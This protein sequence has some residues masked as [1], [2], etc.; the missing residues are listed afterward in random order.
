MMFRAVNAGLVRLSAFES[1]TAP[2]APTALASDDT[3]LD[4]VRDWIRE[5]WADDAF[6]AAVALA[7]PALA[8]RIEAIDEGCAIDSRRLRRAA[9]ALLR[10]RLRVDN[11]A[12]PFGLFAGITP[13]ETMPEAAVEHGTAH[14]AAA[15]PDAIF[16]H[17]AIIALEPEL[18]HQLTVVANNLAAVHGGRL[19]LVSPA[20]DGPSPVEASIA[21]TPA[22]M[23]ALR[24][25]ADP[26]RFD[27]L[28]EKLASEFPHAP[29]SK[30]EPML[31]ALVTEDI[32]LTALRPPMTE[33]DPLAYLVLEARVALGTTTA[34]TA[35]Q[36]RTLLQTRRR[37]RDFERTVGKPH[38]LRAACRR[39]VDDTGSA[40]DRPELAVDLRIDS[41][42][43]LPSTVIDEAEVAAASLLR[44]TR[45]PDGSPSW[46]DFHHRFLERYG[47]GAL[48]P[49]RDLV[50][51]VSGIGYPATFRD[52]QLPRPPHALTDRDRLLIASAHQAVADRRME[53]DLDDPSLTGFFVP[54]PTPPPHVGITFHLRAKSLRDIDAGQFTLVVEGAGRAV[55]TT[56][57]RFLHL[58]SDDERQRFAAAW[59]D[60]PTATAGAMRLQ[61]SGPPLSVTTGNVGRV[62][63]VLAQRLALGEYPTEPGAAIGIDDLA[64][65]A[66]LGGLRLV[67]LADGSAIEPMVPNAIEPVSRLHPLQR[68]LTELPRARS[69]VYAEFDWGAASALPTLPAVRSGRTI[70]APARWRITGDLLPGKQRTWAEWAAAWN[71]VR[72]ARRIPRHVYLGDSDIRNRID[73]EA[74]GH[75]AFL[76]EQL[77]SSTV[78]LREAPGESDWD[79]I[80]GRAHE[81]T[82]PLAARTVPAPARLPT[83]PH[84]ATTEDEHLPGAGGWL[85]AKIYTRPQHLD[86]LITTHLSTLLGT[87]HE[88]LE[89]WFLRYRD[90]AAHL[91]LRIRLSEATGYGVAAEHLGV[92]AADLRRR[93]MISHLQ[94]DTYTPETGRF[95]HGAAMRAAEGVFAADSVAALAQIR[96]TVAAPVLC[97]A[98]FI[99]IATAWTGSASAAGQ[100]LLD[101]I[102]RSGLPLDRGH[103]A[104]L[105]DLESIGGS[106][107][108]AT[109]SGRAV[110]AS[111][112][113][114]TTAIVAYKQALSSTGQHQD[115]LTALLHLHYVRAVG[116][117]PDGERCCLRLARAAE[118]ARTA[119]NRRSNR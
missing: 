60:L 32:L 14:R 98:S 90:P 72:H 37:L 21:A 23:A 87:W 88:P 25:A 49:V 45:F 5:V 94:L 116:I 119:R 97:A 65:T 80:G 2:Q 115:A 82:L 10:Y 62:P 79:W 12:T 51:P 92:W 114:R 28:V 19:T 75:L 71:Q 17:R 93:S 113:R 110:L 58:F 84:P 24:F 8:A 55:G 35:E 56:E 34:R 44:L 48:V 54:A 22:V 36:I 83:A 59:S 63:T 111:W 6:A 27:T 30:V 86:D 64:V 18:L 52:S 99:D 78:V 16:L 41:R 13:L 11:R 43:G 38:E 53:I 76:R 95:G 67:N 46:G 70:L 91:R 4:G 57:G 40:T 109:D 117:D 69:S 42:I 77:G 68:F 15:R 9:M 105:L 108:G 118:L 50:N 61:L 106:S 101:Q 26:I 112:K 89:W 85:Y 29:A 103:V 1:A 104:E 20:P 100:W 66:D 31:R 33:P 3:G 73:L 81:I 47:L 96:H 39:A 74:S 7:S 107:L 102:D